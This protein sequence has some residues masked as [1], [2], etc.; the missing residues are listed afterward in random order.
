MYWGKQT[1][2]PTIYGRLYSNFTAVFWTFLHFLEKKCLNMKFVFCH[3][4]YGIK[5]IFS[6][7][8]ENLSNFC[9]FVSVYIVNPT[10]SWNSQE[11]HEG[12]DMPLIS[13]KI[14]IKLSWMHKV[15][16]LELGRVP[17]FLALDNSKTSLKIRENSTILREKRHPKKFLLAYYW[18]L[19]VMG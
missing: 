1:V 7:I 5:A 11:V 19:V 9:I 2:Y 3:K 18:N 12:A 17:A 6:K 8:A 13:V 16:S 10:L 15:L 4:D 14:V